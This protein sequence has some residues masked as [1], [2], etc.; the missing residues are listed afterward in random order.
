MCK[1][2]NRTH[3]HCTKISFKRFFP[4]KQSPISF[5]FIAHRPTQ[6]RRQK[7]VHFENKE[8]HRKITESGQQLKKNKSV[9]LLAGG[10]MHQ[11]CASSKNTWKQKSATKIAS[12][13]MYEI[14]FFDAKYQKTNHCEPE[15]VPGSHFANSVDRINFLDKTE[16]RMS[17]RTYI[18]AKS[19]QNGIIRFFHFR[20]VWLYEFIRKWIFRIVDHCITRLSY[21]GQLYTVHTINKHKT[22]GKSNVFKCKKHIKLDLSDARTVPPNE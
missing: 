5:N 14:N 9:E 8:P 16:W 2:K 1:S 15:P 10:E 12:N 17:C 22:F 19:I 13:Y 3:H 18:Y 11:K 21:T 4:D 20:C 7:I 6:K